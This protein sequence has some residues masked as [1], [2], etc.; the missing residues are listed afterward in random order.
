[1][2]FL[3][4][5]EDYLKIMVDNNQDIALFIS[6]CVKDEAKAW[7][8]TIKRQVH[9]FDSFEQFFKER[10]WNE[11]IQ[12]SL[13]SKFNSGR[14]NSRGNKSRVAYATELLNI[15]TELDMQMDPQEIIRAIARHFEADVSR[16]VRLQN[17]QSTGDLY[18]FLED[19]DKSE[20]SKAQYLNKKQFYNNKNDEKRSFSSEKS[21]NSSEKTN[22]N[23][24]EP[25]KNNNYQKNGNKKFDSKKSYHTNMISKKVFVKNKPKDKEKEVNIESSGDSSPL[26][27][28]QSQ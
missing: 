17:I 24:Q 12:S 15:V 25:V 9:D 11:P 22:S 5:L 7:F 1:M 8:F 23:R 26:Q 2:S 27:K 18:D 16:A 14:Y 21:G 3:S 13:R 10:Y 20:R 19:L 6:Q 28:E 4:E